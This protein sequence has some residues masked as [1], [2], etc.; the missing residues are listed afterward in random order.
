M[1]KR[2]S[3]YLSIGKKIKGAEESQLF[4]KPCFK[5]NGKAFICFFEDEMVF[6]LNGTQHK[7]LSVLTVPNCLTLPKRNAP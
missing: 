7:E 4:G 3:L 6:K 5:V 2:E 1:S